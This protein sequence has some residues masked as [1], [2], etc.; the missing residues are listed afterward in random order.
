MYVCLSAIFKV[1]SPCNALKLL[2]LR[3][4][5]VDAATGAMNFVPC[6]AVV[7]ACILIY[8]ETLLLQSYYCPCHCFPVPGDSRQGVVFA[9]V[10]YD[11]YLFARSLRC[12]LQRCYIVRHKNMPLDILS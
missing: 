10:C 8:F 5:N 3:M 7:H 1:A 6:T 11:V 4:L 9:R 2:L 12:L